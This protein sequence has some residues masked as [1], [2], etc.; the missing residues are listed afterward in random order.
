MSRNG[1]IPSSRPTDTNTRALRDAT[2]NFELILLI[3]VEAS[4][5][6]EAQGV[7]V[8]TTDC[9]FDP[10]LRKWNIYLNL[11]FHSLWCPGKARR[12]VAPLNTQCPQNSAGSGERSILTLG[13]LC[14]ACCAIQCDAEADFIS[15][16]NYF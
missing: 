10:H 9:W 12:C 5:G 1:R 6:A 4:R 11:F 2:F 8:N 13:S 15:M 16:C 7:T 3:L 14:I